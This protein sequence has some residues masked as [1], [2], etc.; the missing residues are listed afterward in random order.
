MALIYASAVNKRINQHQTT[1]KSRKK[2][3][4][5]HLA[6]NAQEQPHSVTIVHL[7]QRSNEDGRM[8]IHTVEEALLQN[9][10]G[11]GVSHEMTPQR[12]RSTSQHSAPCSYASPLAGS[13]TND[14]EAKTTILKGHKRVQRSRTSCG[15]MP[16][17]QNGGIMR[18]S[19]H[20]VGTV[21]TASKQ[22]S[23]SRRDVHRFSGKSPNGV[24]LN[25]AGASRSHSP[26]R[27]R[28]SSL[29]RDSLSL[30]AEEWRMQ[31]DLAIEE[32]TGVTGDSGKPGAFQRM[33]R[34]FSKWRLSRADDK[35]DR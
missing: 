10:A 21:E 11:G 34:K 9:V 1:Q 26:T 8:S 16:R 35:D 27:E 30:D 15:D 20:P 25:E 24:D 17:K 7:R 4:E 14:P 18:K 32:E 3:L 5:H 33:R 22:V 28:F 29:R 2:S 19:S 23:L 13:S 31:M 12:K 6:T